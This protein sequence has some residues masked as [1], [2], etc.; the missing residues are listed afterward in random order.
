M[1]INTATYREY[2]LEE[3]EEGAGGGGGGGGGCSYSGADQG[4]RGGAGSEKGQVDQQNQ[5]ARHLSQRHRFQVNLAAT[6]K[7]K[8]DVQFKS[9]VCH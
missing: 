6:F 2:G 7:H 5:G 4:L 3:A 8:F 1:C 9:M